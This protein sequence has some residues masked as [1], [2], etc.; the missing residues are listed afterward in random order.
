MRMCERIAN[1]MELKTHEKKKGMK[2]SQIK[3]RNNVIKRKKEQKKEIDRKRTF[4][5]HAFFGLPY[6]FGFSLIQINRPFYGT[7]LYFTFQVK[8]TKFCAHLFQIGYLLLFR[9]FSFFH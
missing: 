1:R 4:C 6:R 7:F 5:A 8:M 2:A 3:P 9:I